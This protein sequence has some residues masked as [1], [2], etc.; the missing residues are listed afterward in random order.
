MKLTFQTWTIADKVQLQQNLEWDGPK[1]SICLLDP[2]VMPF[3][4]M[5]SI[6]MTSFLQ[7]L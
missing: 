1:L 6:L 3:L 4:L 2:L 7:S 5:D